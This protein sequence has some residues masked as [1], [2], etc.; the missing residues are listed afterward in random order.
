MKFKYKVMLYMTA[1]LSFFYV[2][3][4]CLLIFVSFQTS[5]NK[6]KSNALNTHRMIQNMLLVSKDMNQR[7]YQYT[8][9][10]LASQNAS[11]WKGIRLKEAKNRILYYESGYMPYLLTQDDIQT[12]E[13]ETCCLIR[14]IQKGTSHFVQISGLIDTGSTSLVLEIS[15]DVTQVYAARET[16]L[17][18]YKAILA[19][20]LTA[21]SIGA[22]LISEKLTKPIRQLS[23]T[24]RKIAGGNL[25]IRSN[26]HSGDEIELLSRDFNHMTDSLEDNIR[27]MADSIRRQEEFMGSFAHELKTPM[28]SIIGYADLM[29]SQA[30]TKE[31]QQEA[32]KEFI[33]YALTKDVAQ[34][35][36]DDQFAFSAVNGVEQQNETVSGVAKDIANGKVSNFPDHYYPNGFDLS[37]IL[38]QFALNKV[39]G[40]DD[41]ENISETLASCDEQYDAA[42]VE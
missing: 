12:M 4:A 41:T 30:L 7:A 27:K 15:Q 40:M 29:R 17:Q 1:F 22:L 11:M 2:V 3:S 33:R 13:E 34:E 14:Y 6:E 10:Q 31:E 8:L 25:S 5:L 23:E 32:A 20:V 28:T 35:Y 18:I 21:G 37:T 42:N 16:Q 38:Q 36:I 24:S 9:N 39:N 26:I 19:F